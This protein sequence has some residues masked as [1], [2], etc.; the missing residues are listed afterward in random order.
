MLFNLF[1]SS[2]VIVSGITIL[3]IVIAYLLVNKPACR[4]IN[5]NEIN[6]VAFTLRQLLMLFINSWQLVS[7]SEISVSM[8]ISRIVAN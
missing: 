6:M 8:T 2:V 4:P 1:L 5:V 3:L 7:F